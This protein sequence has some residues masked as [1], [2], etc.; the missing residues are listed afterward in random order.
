MPVPIK[1]DAVSFVSHR[2]DNVQA[3]C[4]TKREGLVAVPEHPPQNGQQQKGGQQNQGGNMGSNRP[5]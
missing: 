5:K 2:G 3:T 4:Q 1:G